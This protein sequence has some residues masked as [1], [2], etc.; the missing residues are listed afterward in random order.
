MASV[1]VACE[2]SGI[3]RNAF[4]RRGHDCWSCDIR[5]SDDRSNHHIIGDARPLI[6]E[7]RWNLIVIAHPPCTRLCNSGVRWL[8]E[9]PTQISAEH[10][11]PAEVASY[12]RMK[13][14]ERLE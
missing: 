13:R 7:R 10:Y 2:T 5:P 14:R 11:T 12:Q 9:P 3:V 1:L 8:T 4:L 6:R